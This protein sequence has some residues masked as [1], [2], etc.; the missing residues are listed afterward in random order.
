MPG[1]PGVLQASLATTFLLLISAAGLGTGL[2]MWL[3]GCCWV[4]GGGDWG[5]W[6]EGTGRG[7]GGQ[8]GSGEEP[9][10]GELGNAPVETA[11]LVGCTKQMYGKLEGAW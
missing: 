5:R 10:G 7:K 4:E 11:C 1:G 8:E 9:A 6:R 2:G 3:T